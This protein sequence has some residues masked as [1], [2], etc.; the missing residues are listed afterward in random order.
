MNGILRFNRILSEKTYKNGGSNIKK[1][2]LGVVVAV[3]VIS[4]GITSTFAIGSAYGR[5]YADAD[6]NGVCDNY[7]A[8]VDG[9]R[10]AG[11]YCGRSY[12]DADNNGVCDNYEAIV[13]GVRAAG[14]VL[15]PKLCR[16][17]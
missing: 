12:V 14:A 4:I 15:R 11:R 6:N 9:V 8:V 17:G 13:D 7:E 5:N 10:A 1:I 16:R 2:L 3:L